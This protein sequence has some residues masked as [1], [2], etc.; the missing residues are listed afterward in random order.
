MKEAFA[1]A[2]CWNKPPENGIPGLAIDCQD[3]PAVRPTSYNEIAQLLNTSGC[4]TENPWWSWEV[5]GMMITY[6][7]KVAISPGD[8]I[9]DLGRSNYLV[10]PDIDYHRLKNM[11]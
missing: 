3:H 8:W 7:G 1:K 10:L 4:S 2:V 11:V 5:M 9:V 6:K